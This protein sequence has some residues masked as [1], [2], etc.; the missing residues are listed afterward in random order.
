MRPATPTGIWSMKKLTIETAISIRLI[1]SRSW[2]S[3]IAQVDGGGSAAISLRPYFCRRLAASAAVS[4]F[5]GSEWS[6]VSACSASSANQAGWSC[7]AADVVAVEVMAP[8]SLIG[9]PQRR[10]K[11]TLRP[12]AVIS[13]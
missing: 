4:P 13:C 8:S 10:P 11:S 3:T 6:S 1:G 2:S 5:A 12:R 7:G 9:T